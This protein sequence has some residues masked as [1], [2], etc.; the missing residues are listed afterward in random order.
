[1]NALIQNALVHN[2]RYVTLLP[3]SNGPC[4]QGP[5]IMAPIATDLGV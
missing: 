4:P 3:S 5:R 2:P 1:M